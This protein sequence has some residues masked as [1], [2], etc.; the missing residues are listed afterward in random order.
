MQVDFGQTTLKNVDGTWTKVYVA[1]FLLSHFRPKYA[2]CQSRPF[3]AVDLA[4]A[5]HNC[6]RYWGGMPREIVFDQDSIVCV[7]ENSGD[8]IYI[9][10]FEKFRQDCRMEVYLCRGAN[11][12]SE[13]KIENTVKFIKGNFLN[14]RLYVDNEILNRCCLDRLIRHCEI[15]NMTG[16]SYRLAH[17]RSIHYRP[18]EQDWHTLW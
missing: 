9:Y 10:E 8:I 12:E 6:F 17:H 18:T 13:G 2:Q 16:N 11:P 1:A 4:D 3:T 7:S 15:I 5:C 14:N